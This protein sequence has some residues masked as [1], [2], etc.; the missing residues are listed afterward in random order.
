MPTRIYR[1]ASGGNGKMPSG[2]IQANFIF[3]KLDDPELLSVCDCVVVVFSVTEAG[4][5]KE[6]ED[7]LQNLWKSGE[8]N[9][10]ANIIVGNKTDLVRTRQV[11]IDGKSCFVILQGLGLVLASVTKCWPLNCNKNVQT[12]FCL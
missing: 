4:S 9:T 3:S 5:V 7:I 2:A 1:K 10:K 8:L 6:A 11:P 12:V